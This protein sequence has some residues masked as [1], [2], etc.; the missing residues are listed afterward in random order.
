MIF[1]NYEENLNLVKTLAQ[2]DNSIAIHVA[3]LLTESA[4][5]DS[6]GVTQYRPYYVVAKLLEQASVH[7]QLSSA[8]GV[9][10]TG[11]AVPIKSYLDLQLGMDL[12]NGWAI[13]AGFESIERTQLEDPYPFTSAVHTTPAF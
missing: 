1:S 6:N 12:K 11:M 2:P 5:I 3:T 7:Q 8:D 4:V 9:V 13:P 10:F